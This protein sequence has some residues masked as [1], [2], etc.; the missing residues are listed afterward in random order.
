VA[1]VAGLAAI[2]GLLASAPQPSFAVRAITAALT[3]AAALPV[4]RRFVAVEGR[5]AVREFEWD[6]EGR[7]RVRD[8]VGRWHDDATLASAAIAGPL[9]LVSWRTRERRRLGAVIDA[10]CVPVAV[11]RRLKGRL[12]ISCRAD[13]RRRVDGSC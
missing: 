10:T 5:G 7:W 11:H 8:G 6:G 9:V 13:A 3:L 2:L 1:S 12:R 4:L